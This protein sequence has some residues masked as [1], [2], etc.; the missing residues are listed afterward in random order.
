MLERV[1]RT[2]EGLWISIPRWAWESIGCAVKFYIS[3][4]RANFSED[5]MPREILLYPVPV[6]QELVLESRVKLA[7]PEPEIEVINI[8]RGKTDISAIVAKVP[9]DVAS[10]SKDMLKGAFGED[11]DTEVGVR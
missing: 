4:D 5:G 2:K 6:P 3:L 10:L 7:Q 8:N 11:F 1:E 9:T